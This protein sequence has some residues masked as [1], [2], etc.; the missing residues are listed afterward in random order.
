MAEKELRVTLLRHTA[1]PELTIA[2]AG[3]MCYA[4]VDVKE[5]QEKMSSDKVE[6]LIKRLVGE[7]HFSVLEHANFTF[8]IDGLS[9]ACTHQLVRH[10]LAS[11]SQQS[12]RYVDENDFG[13]VVPP[14]IK[15][16]E[17]KKAYEKF[18]EHMKKSNELYAELVKEGIPK[19]DARFVLPN[20]AETRIIV[21]MNA[22]SLMN[23]FERRLCTRAQW[24]IRVLAQE[25]LKEVQK[26]APLLFRGTGPICERL[27]YCPEG[28][29]CGRFPVKAEA[30]KGA[31]K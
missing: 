1:E 13:Y 6:K 30:L 14:K 15:D 5:L 20:A 22:R 25:M 7:G 3:H 11:Y 27:G 9:R 29:S 16:G 2:M 31:G 4:G 19:E 21:T 24:E 18:L 23:F 28:K 8:G 26:V 12:Q 10:R 17:N